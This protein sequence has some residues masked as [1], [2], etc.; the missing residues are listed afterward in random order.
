MVTIK[1]LIKLDFY[2]MKPLFK[3][4]TGFLIIPIIL[5]FVVDKGTSIMVTLT[6]LV[7]MLN[8]VFAIAE[9]SNFSKLYGVLPIRKN[10]NI[11]S[12]YLFSLFII[13]C[14]AIVSFLIYIIL[15]IFSNEPMNWFGGIESLTVSIVIASF[16]ISIQY[17]FYYKFEYSKAM[18]MAIL[19]YIV[20]FA[21]GAPLIQYLM[22]NMTFYTSITGI[23]NYFHSNTGLLVIAGA[24]LSIL[25]ISISCMLSIKIQKKE[26]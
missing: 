7:F 10:V 17:P 5:G 23:V 15:S 4:M 16:F 3:I 9:K 18:L 2:A 12:R 13:L 21:I 11:V 19:P 1:K 8:S 22:K 20:F 14:G 24:A 25:L 6:F 26:F